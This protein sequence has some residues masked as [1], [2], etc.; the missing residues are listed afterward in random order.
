MSNT[1]TADH[2]KAFDESFALSG[3]IVADI[4][5]ASV[6]VIV[7]R[8]FESS[9]GYDQ[10]GTNQVIATGEVTAKTTD[11]PAITITTLVT[12]ETVVYRITDNNAEGKIC[13]TLEL[14]SP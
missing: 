14:E 8:D 11:L 9:Q 2:V 13:R 3:S 4:D 10:D 6:N 1:V 5:G 12:L 7:S